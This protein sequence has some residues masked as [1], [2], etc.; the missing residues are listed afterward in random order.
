MGHLKKGGERSKG[1]SK[2][3]CVPKV[4]H[5]G[6]EPPF[7]CDI[8]AI[9]DARS[10]SRLIRACTGYMRTQSERVVGEREVRT[11]GI[12]PCRYTT[13]CLGIFFIRFLRIRYRMLYDR[14]LAIAYQDRNGDFNGDIIGYWGP[15]GLTRTE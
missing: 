10:Y 11:P 9:A 8:N 3:D 14:R 2:P 4:P 1:R 12:S 5:P 13:F 15:R 7:G 6:C